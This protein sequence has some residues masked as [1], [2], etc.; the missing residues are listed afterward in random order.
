[1]PDPDLDALEHEPYVDRAIELAR[2]AGERG[3]GPFGSLLVL[4]DEVVLEAR[5]R[6]RTDDD[7]TRHPELTLARRAAR[8]LTPAE[9]ARTVMYTST[10]PC[11]MCSG[12]LAIAGLGAVVYSVSN[13]RAAEAFGGS[14]GV[15]CEE[16]CDRW[17]RP[18]DVVGGVL[19]ADGLAVRRAFQAD[20]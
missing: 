14:E 11:P 8:E 15:P 16:I 7:I 17:G 2:E 5:N 4:D 12:G 9:R 20:G 19:E 13:A 3:D 18:V 10:E 1:M 6:E